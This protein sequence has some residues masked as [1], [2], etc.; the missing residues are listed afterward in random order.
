MTM[1]DATTTCRVKKLA[2]EKSLILRITGLVPF[3]RQLDVWQVLKTGPVLS[4]ILVST[5]TPDFASF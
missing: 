5:F 1:T 2:S 3:A 4:F